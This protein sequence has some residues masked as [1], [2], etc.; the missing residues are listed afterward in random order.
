MPDA[1]A[2]LVAAIDVGG[3]T[4]KGALLDADLQ[5]VESVVVPTTRGPAALDAVLGV[6]ARLVQAGRGEVRAVGIGVPGVVDVAGGVVRHSVNL[7]WRDVPVRDAAAAALR[8]PVAVEHDVTAAG[9]A[10]RSHG[11]GRR[12]DD[13]LVV[14][15]GTGISAVVFAGGRLVRGG[16]R[17]AGE[18]GHVRVA[19]S[20]LPCSCGGRGCLETVVSAAAVATAYARRTGRP[21]AGA[22]EVVAAVEAGHAQARQVWDDAVRAL[23][24]ALAA[25]VTLLGT[26]LVVVGGGLA[27]AGDLLVHPLR[28][29]LATACTVQAPPKVQAAQFGARAG[30]VGA[31]LAARRLLERSP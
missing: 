13:V 24:E 19:G 4:I 16:S 12:A 9:L 8:L 29:G 18:L 28:R 7:G 27:E 25:A 5:P 1:E 3:T 30:M 22:Q 23:C 17:Q 6:A 11:A 14:V 10:E 15:L 31:A 20:D 21:V 26:D 2:G